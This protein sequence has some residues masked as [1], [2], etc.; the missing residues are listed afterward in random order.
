MGEIGRKT[1]DVLL[2]YTSNNMREIKLRGLSPED[3]FIETLRGLPENEQARLELIKH[4]DEESK[5]HL[6]KL[7]VT[8][9]LFIIETQFNVIKGNPNFFVAIVLIFTSTSFWQAY[10]TSENLRISRKLNDDN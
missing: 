3:A 7:L 10:L 1:C 5:D 6:A 8:A 2:Q 9:L 4:F